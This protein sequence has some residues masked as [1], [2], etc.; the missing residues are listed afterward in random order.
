MKNPLKN[1]VSMLIFLA[2][3]AI[4]CATAAEPFILFA[5]AGV[6]SR[7]AM[8]PPTGQSFPTSGFIVDDWLKTSVPSTVLAAQAAA[9]VVPDPY[10]GM[11]LRNIP[12]RELSHRP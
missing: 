3:L 10:Y 9:K 5:M 2:T 4:P 7:R 12:G 6:C 11:N 8:S 1:H